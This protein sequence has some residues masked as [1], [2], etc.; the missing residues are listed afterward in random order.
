MF[1][2]EKGSLILKQNGGV[3]L[4]TNHNDRDQSKESSLAALP[5]LLLILV[6]A[7]ILTFSGG[8]DG[9]FGYLHTLKMSRKDIYNSVTCAS[10]MLHL[11]QEAM[12][13]ET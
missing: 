11:V 4:S 2:C 12:V 5:D 3:P 10:N 9:D 6:P 7:G 8:K 1:P 13:P